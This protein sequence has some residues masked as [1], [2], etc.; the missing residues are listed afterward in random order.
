ML[1]NSRPWQHCFPLRPS[2]TCK[3]ELAAIML[4]CLAP[5]M[6]V[7]VI[8]LVAKSLVSGVYEMNPESP[9]LSLAYL[10]SPHL[11][12]CAH[13]SL[14][15]D[16][17][18]RCP[19]GELSSVVYCVAWPAHSGMKARPS[20]LIFNSGHGFAPHRG[21]SWNHEFCCPPNSKL[22]RLSR[23]EWL[24]HALSP[25]LDLCKQCQ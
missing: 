15:P 9:S 6:R 1:A 23:G 16:M 14:F 22:P 12:D 7:S 2:C 3:S 4:K 18:S 5:L 24:M 20:F 11:H 19:R 10:L 13:L 21:S 25:T 8:G 17:C